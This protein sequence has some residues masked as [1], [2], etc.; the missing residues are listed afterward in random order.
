VIESFYVSNIYGFFIGCFRF[1]ELN[2]RLDKPLNMKEAYFMTLSRIVLSLVFPGLVLSACS[3]GGTDSDPK[4]WRTDLD[5]LEPALLAVAPIGSDEFDLLAVGGPLRG[6][7]PPALYRRAGSSGDWLSLPA[8]SGFT[9]AVWWSWSTSADNVWVVG[10]DLQVAHGEIQDLELMDIP[11]VKN[12]TKATL[13]GVWGSGPDDVWMVGG[14]P[15]SSDGPEGVIFRYN[16]QQIE[17]LEI[18]G[19]ASIAAEETFF[20]VWGTGPKDVTIVGTNGTILRY[21]GSNWSL[22][23]NLTQSRLL[24][25]HGRSSSDIYAV[26]GSFTGGTVLRFDGSQWEEIGELGMPFLNGVYAA[27]DGSVWV[28][29]PTAYVARWDG[30]TWTQFDVGVFGR[31]YHGIYTNSQETLVTGGLLAIQ[32][33]S[34][35]GILS[36]FGLD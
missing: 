2:P 9:G 6:D 24:T 34:R 27:D 33:G 26:G 10:E 14:S 13:Y 19:T 15:L 7:A 35:M 29:G 20:K 18:T 36:R 28:C 16:G 22:Q 11:Q 17:K 12:A 25:V 5:E 3:G 21:D 1:V 4:T 32:P 8:P 31:D 23:N 30:E